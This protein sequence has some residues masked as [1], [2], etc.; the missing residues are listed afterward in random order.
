MSQAPYIISPQALHAVLQQTDLVIIDLCDPQLFAQGHIP[1]ARHLPYG[2]IVRHTPPTFGLMPSAEHLSQIFSSLG[3]TPNSWVV[4]CDDEG[5]GK[6]ARLL[7]TLEAAGH[8]KLSLLDGGIHSWKAAKLP[9]STDSQ[10]IEHSHYPLTFSNPSVIAERSYIQNH[11]SDKSVR[12]LDARSPAEYAGTDVRAARGGHIPGAVNIEWTDALD[13]NNALQLKPLTE[14]QAMF[15]AKGIHP[16][17]E[18]I[19]YCH[20][21]HRSALS[22][23]VLRHLG[24]TKLRGY[25]GSWSDWGNQNDTPIE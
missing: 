16:E 10:P 1:G 4:A 13:R 7:W 5:G 11:L 19:V 12:I 17:L 15:S 14:L 3:I 24:F 22:F 23:A 8:R 18:V 9:L 21:H 25:P 20:S 2:Q 6:A